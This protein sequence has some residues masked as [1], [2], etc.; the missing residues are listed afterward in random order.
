MQ[1]TVSRIQ[2]ATPGFTGEI[3]IDHILISRG[4]EYKKCNG[5]IEIDMS[6]PTTTTTS[7]TSELKSSF[8]QI[9]SWKFKKRVVFGLTL[10]DKYF[11]VSYDDGNYCFNLES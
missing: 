2:L 8:I 3:Y 9:I 10:V 6:E 4:S 1:Q 7:T 5:R 11:F